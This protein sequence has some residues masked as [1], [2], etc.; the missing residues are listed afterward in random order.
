[1]ACIIT[2]TIIVCQVLVLHNIWTITGAETEVQEEAET[3]TTNDKVMEI[4]ES[5]NNH[6]TGNK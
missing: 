5:L 4:T 1:M 2:I 3:K 6:L